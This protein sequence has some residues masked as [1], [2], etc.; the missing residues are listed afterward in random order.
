MAGADVSQKAAAPKKSGGLTI[1]KPKRRSAVR[2]DMTPMVDVA[3]LLLIFFMV[4]TVFRKPLAMEINLPEAEA[5]IKVPEENVMTI[6][7]RADDSMMCRVGTAAPQPLTWPDLY[8]TLRAGV[9]QNPALIVLVKIHRAARYDSMV[10][11]MD[12]LEDAKMER[13][14]V[15]AMK[16]EDM[17]LMQEAGR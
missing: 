6:Y 4:T 9:E 3:F 11:M 5:S 1:R 16:D 7:V 13:F 14:S 17:R 8:R 12:T 15:I 10:E 2:I